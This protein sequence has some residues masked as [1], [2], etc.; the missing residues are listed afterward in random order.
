MDSIRSSIQ[1][2]DANITRIS[3]LQQSALNALDESSS[4]RQQAEVD[5]L[6]SETKALG[7]SLR[8]RLRKLATWPI[9]GRNV[10]IRND[11]V[12]FP[13]D[14]LCLHIQ[15]QP[16][17]LGVL[18]S[19]F[20]EALQRYQVV[21]QQHRDK[22]KER[23]ARQF[24]IVKPDARPEEIAAVVDDI[25]PGSN[26]IFAEAVRI[27]AGDREIELNAY[28]MHRCRRQIDLEKQGRPNQMFSDA[29]RTS[30]KSSRRFQ[31]SY[32]SSTTWR[33]WWRSKRIQSTKSTRLR[34]R[35]RKILNKGACHRFSSNF[36]FS[37]NN[38]VFKA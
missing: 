19:Q 6:A 32:N 23:V 12:S 28:E 4:Q 7:N 26:Q 25:G 20:M 37:W 21:E 9:Q 13:L 3:S 33:P 14:V 17:Q 27:F 38:I 11:Q 30:K 2:Y 34:K 16:I 5:G 10:Q 24:R 35:S 15:N 22:Q 8:E 18:K 1:Q 31:N 36:W 29:T